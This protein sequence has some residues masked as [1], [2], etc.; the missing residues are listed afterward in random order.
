ARNTLTMV[1]FRP[2][3]F[4]WNFRYPQVSLYI[5]LAYRE[6]HGYTHLGNRGGLY[7]QTDRPGSG[8]PGP[9]YPEDSR[10]RAAPWLGDR[11]APETGLRRCPVC[12]R[13]IALPCPAQA[14]AGGLDYCR[15]ETKR[16]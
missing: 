8:Y 1:K 10:V 13:R 2:E 15:M 9:A 16:E 3:A 7:E 5:P 12:Q 11:A 6:G 4:G 14:G